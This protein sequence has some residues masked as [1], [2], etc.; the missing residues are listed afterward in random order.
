MEDLF[1]E[2]M[3]VLGGAG[4][5][6]SFPTEDWTRPQKINPETSYAS[7]VMPMSA[8]NAT[9]NL[10]YTVGQLQ[11]FQLQEWPEMDEFG[12]IT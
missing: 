7:G 4:G 9:T 12:M 3:N 5:T 6:G 11:K 1:D 8:E 10:P 2:V